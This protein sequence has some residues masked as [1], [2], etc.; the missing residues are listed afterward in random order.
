MHPLF[1]CYQFPFCFQLPRLIET[2]GRIIASVIK[3]R[4]NYCLL[5][6]DHKL[7]AWGGLVLSAGRDVAGPVFDRDRDAFPVHQFSRRTTAGPCFA[8]I[9]QPA[10]HISGCQLIPCD[11][12]VVIH[13]LYEVGG[14]IGDT[15]I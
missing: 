8:A 5:E 14:E 3:D 6:E 15:S 7:Q 1:C 4:G 2:F 9:S 12:L 10:E 11:S 13:A